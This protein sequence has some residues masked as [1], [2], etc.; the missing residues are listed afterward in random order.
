MPHVLLVNPAPPRK[1]RGPRP[2][3]A[4][5]VRQIKAAAKVYNERKPKM[6]TTRKKTRT[7]AQRAAT[8][9]LIRFNK[10]RSSGA[11]RAARPARKAPPVRQKARSS[12]AAT[13]RPVRR[14][15]RQSSARAASSAGRTLRYRRSNPIGGFITDT[16]IPSAVG[17][18]G[19]LA[20]NVAIAMLPLPVAMKVGPMAPLVRVAGA[21][22]LGMLAGQFMGRKIGEQVTAGALTVTLYDFARTQLARLKIPGLSMY[23]DGVGDYIGADEMEALGYIDSGQQVGE[24][25]GDESMAMA[26][27]ETGV[28]R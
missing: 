17:G 26:G 22:G 9:K 7:A 20:L 8:A 10:K 19:A 25:I 18:A 5:E 3:S 21:V 24:Y 23:P 16:L 12:P 2:M 1:A 28:Y 6:A 11:K 13:S 14:K 27:Y 15:Y 4:S